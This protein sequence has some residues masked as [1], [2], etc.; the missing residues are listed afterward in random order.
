MAA[1]CMGN[2]SSKPMSPM[3]S[4][5]SCLIPNS[6]NRVILPHSAMT[7]SIAA[8]S[9]FRR[10]AGG[11]T[12]K[13]C[14]TIYVG[15]SRSLRCRCGRLRR[16]RLWHGLPAAGPL[17]N[18]FV[19]PLAAPAMRACR[20]TRGG[21]GTGTRA[22]RA[23]APG[24]EAPAAHPAAFMA[25]F[26]GAAM[27][28]MTAVCWRARRGGGC[29]GWNAAALLPANAQNSSL[30]RTRIRC[31]RGRPHAPPPQTCCG[32]GRGTA[33]RTM[34]FAAPGTCPCIRALGRRRPAS[35]GRRSLS[36]ANGG[37]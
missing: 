30:G 1:S 31:R 18:G 15:A 25:R 9:L 35:A 33:P 37:L 8:P 20:H 2:A 16:R 10:L 7:E 29:E 13:P 34:F 27:G 21:G 4:S 17:R 26:G 6:S 14:R 32:L 11:T 36:R 12:N 24:L 5:S 22:E 23:Q 3:A 28:A 19:Q